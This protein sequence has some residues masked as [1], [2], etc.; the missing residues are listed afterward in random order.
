MHTVYTLFLKIASFSHLKSFPTKTWF[1]PF[2]FFLNIS[3]HLCV[4]HYVLTILFNTIFVAPFNRLATNY[5]CC[6]FWFP[7]FYVA[8][9]FLLFPQV[10][11]KASRRDLSCCYYDRGQPLCELAVSDMYYPCMR[12]LLIAWAILKALFG[13]DSATNPKHMDITTKFFS[14]IGKVAV[15]QIL[16]AGV[17]SISPDFLENNRSER[18]L[19]VSHACFESLLDGLHDEWKSMAAWKDK[20]QSQNFKMHFQKMLSSRFKCIFI[21]V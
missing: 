18:L 6:W 21:P 2:F 11:K 4:K 1:P 3:T 14:C 5:C 10:K 12:I 7:T 9:C 13:S 17:S 15:Y 8:I 16:K 19:P 20:N